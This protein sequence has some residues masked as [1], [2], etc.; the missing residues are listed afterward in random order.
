MKHI[1]TR[2]LSILLCA[3]MLAA[4]M[5]TAVFADEDEPAEAEDT[6][7]E[8]ASAAEEEEKEEIRYEVTTVS[9]DETM[10]TV[11]GGGKTYL[12]GVDIKVCAI[13]AYGYTF[14]GWTDENGE[15]VSRAAGWLLTVDKDY[16]LTANFE[17]NS[18]N[19]LSF[20]AE[21][22][23]QMAEIDTENR[24]VELRFASDVDLSNVYPYFY[25]ETGTECDT[26]NYA[27]MDLTEPVTIGIGENTWTVTAVQNKVMEEFYVDPVRGD[28]ENRGTSARKAFRTLEAAQ[29]AVRAIEEWTGDVVVHLGKGEYTLDETMKFGLEDSAEKGYAVIWE[30]TEDA[31]E[32]V[33]NSAQ[34]LEGEWTESAD[35]PD[36]ADGLVAWEY[37]AA[38]VEY[39]RDLFVDGEIAQLAGFA[40]DESE[41]GTWAYLDLDYVD[42]TDTGFDVYGELADMYSWHN[43][44]DIEFMFEIGWTCVIIPVVG[45]EQSADGSTVTL[46]NDAFNAA[47]TKGGMQIG[48]PTSI[49]NCFE[50][51]D[52]AGEWYFDRAAE[53]IYY[54]TDGADPNG[55]EIVMPTLEQLVTVDGEVNE[56]RS[57]DF[58]YGL[59]FKNITFRYTAY[60]QPH[61][62]GQVEIQASFCVDLDG[63]HDYKKTYGAFVA[64][65]V[66][67]LRITG[68]IFTDLAAS[69]VDLEY[70]CKG[71]QFVGNSIIDVGANGLCVGSVESRQAQPYSEVW[72][73]GSEL[74]EVG[75]I[76]DS[77]TEY[78]LVMSNSLDGIG[79]RYKGAVAIL[80][81]YVADVTASH[82]TITNAS[83]TGISAGWGWGV[84]DGLG[85]GRN[86][87]DTYR[88]PDTASVQARYV[89]EYNSISGVCQRLAD[90]GG[91]YT[92]S[93][94]PGSKLNRNLFFDNPIVFG[95][96]YLD[97]GAGG[98][99]EIRENIIYN[100]HT[101]FRYHTTGGRAERETA[102]L[103]LFKEG[104]NY[105]EVEPDSKKADETYAAVHAAAGCLPEEAGM[106]PPVIH[107]VDFTE[108]EPLGPAW[109]V[110]VICAAAVLALGAVILVLC[111]KK[112][113]AEQE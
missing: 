112:K 4:L 84:W 80:F 22:L 17:K 5:P 78:H 23:T 6:A 31:N 70:G 34:Y 100:V 50:G 83:Y 35:V 25:L 39:G 90:G 10:G 1:W 20:M 21:G 63:G 85:D 54:I 107:D 26:E 9:A 95:G 52:T 7:G 66:E 105:S 92:L 98:F 61:T 55:M 77:V 65:Y 49:I 60:L 8:E 33:I 41:V 32:V 79:L 74:V 59:T 11:T 44:T 28:D 73:V 99:T 3:V 37:D 15:L 67:G 106:T 27:R 58:V 69:A 46:K 13:P 89:I 36:L 91:V 62:Y 103:A 30:G 18:E 68:C 110:W 64:N 71:C 38:G 93:N 45:I 102:M 48:D 76:P 104:N 2:L 47:R 42:M 111:L 12:A 113:K 19:I 57:A 24:T 16:H 72:P 29:E 101:T 56:D 87:H 82:N 81:G 43:P 75:S 51:L 14:T 40:T 96:I 53:K 86:D 97:E 109:Y 94:M 88:F 108:L